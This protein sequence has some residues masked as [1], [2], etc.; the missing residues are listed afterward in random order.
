[1]SNRITFNGLSSG[2]DTES[3][4]KAMMMRYQTKVDNAKADKVMLEW[5]QEA[6]KS[7]N[8]KVLNFHQKYISNSRLQSTFNQKSVTSSNTDVIQLKEGSTLPEGTHSV[9]VNKLAETARLETSKITKEGV[10]VK[11]STTLEELGI[12]DFSF[13]VTQD[14]KESTI[15]IATTYQDA[16]GNTVNKTLGQLKSELAD[17]MP[18]MNVSFDGNADAFFISSKK[19]GADSSF[20]LS[21]EGEG[22][23]ALAALGLGT[24]DTDGNLVATA[25]G[26]DA[27]LT[28][29]GV[30]VTSSNNQVTVN[31]VTM[32]LVSASTEPV[33]LVSTQDTDAVVDFVTEFVTEYNA[34]IE[35]INTLTGERKSREYGPLTDEQKEDMT[36]EEIKLWEAKAK[37]GL[38]GNDLVLENFTS[39]MRNIL[40]N[41]LGSG[42]SAYDTLA[43]IGIKTGEWQEKGKLNI[44]ED[45]LRQAIEN[46][47]NAVIEMFTEPMEVNEKGEKV[48]GTGGFGAQMFDVV[49]K[50]FERSDD[51]SSN[52]LFSD[53]A[54]VNQITAS[55][56]AISSAQTLFDRMEE[57]YYARF[58]AMEAMMAKYNAQTSVFS[59]MM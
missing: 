59:G 2:I 13:K 15:D 21:A 44:D 12:K 19:S 47:P 36:E 52:F 26:Q 45:K 16:D 35:E 28:Y 7:I 6:Y 49:S 37:Q 38:L 1:M 10:D 31:G 46:D 40:G 42:T 55:E 39:K 33:T 14:G 24:A 17:A 56:K 4:V 50:M 27:S 30:E 32:T 29:N 41:K 43:D 53:K 54:L 22:A 9:V 5:K 51:K 11:E 57:T 58:A 34:L 25:A 8:T 23:K 18:D 3:V 20:T 48:T